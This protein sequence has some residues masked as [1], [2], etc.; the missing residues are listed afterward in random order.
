LHA[1][2][3]RFSPIAL[4]ANGTVLD[5]RGFASSTNTS[6][7]LDGELDVDEADDSER[8]RELLHRLLDPGQR[9][10]VERRWRSTQDESPE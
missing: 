4:L 2:S 1:A 9:L 8:R 10:V 7:V 5:A 6:P 3:T